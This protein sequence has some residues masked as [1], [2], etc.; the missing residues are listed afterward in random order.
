LSIVGADARG[1]VP[2]RRERVG[3]A[4]SRRQRMGVDVDGLRAVSGLRPD[5]IVSGVF[6]RVLRR[7][8]LRD[9]GSVAGD[10]AR[11]GPP[12][13]PQLVP[14]ELSV[15]VCDVPDG[16]IG[17]RLWALGFGPGVF[18]TPL[19]PKASENTMRIPAD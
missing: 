9:E 2:R 10:R 6:R 13:L 11:A 7:R 14:A 16:E 19:K 3:R 1:I 5:A 18:S 17:F 4:R 12:Q 15:R 8:A